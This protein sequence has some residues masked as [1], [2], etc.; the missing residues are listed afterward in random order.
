MVKHT[1]LLKIYSKVS[2][3]VKVITTLH[4]YLAFGPY[5][6]SSE[7]VKRHSVPEP[8]GDLSICK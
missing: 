7:T 1:I 3:F 8:D 6:S 5:L 4:H 2:A